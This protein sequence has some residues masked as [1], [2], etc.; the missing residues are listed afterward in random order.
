MAEALDDLKKQ[1]DDA[2]KLLKDITDSKGGIQALTDNFEKTNETLKETNGQAGDLIAN[3][4]KM[5]GGNGP[6]SATLADLSRAFL[7]TTQ[8]TS[9]FGGE[10]QALTGVVSSVLGPELGKIVASVGLLPSVFDTFTGTTRQFKKDTLELGST[11]G[12]SYEQII[13]KTL[14]YQ[15]A[16]LLANNYTF[17]G[18]DAVR[19]SAVGMAQYGL[20]VDEVTRSFNVAG[21][22]QN[23]LSTG[24]LLATDSGLQSSKV[25]E[26]M[27][28]SARTM[29]YDVENSAK[30]IVAL[31]NIARDTG[32][33]L[34]QI[35]DKVFNTAKE[36]SRLGL[37]VDS[38]SP[39]IQRFTENLGAGFKGL[40]VDEVNKLMKGLESQINTTNAAFMSM[41]GGLSRPGAGV[42]EAQLAFEDAFKNPIE[43][44]K[45]LSS[46]LAGVTGGKIIKFEEARANPELANQFKL[47]RDLLGQLTGNRDPQSQRT[48]LA[49][50]SDLQS[51]RQLSSSQ[52]KTL[53]D[54]MKSG[55][56][57]QNEMASTT[58]Q[59]DRITV[60]LQTETNILLG[61]ILNKLAPSQ[62]QG[63]LV[64][65]GG[66]YAQAGLEQTIKFAQTI[67]DKI[68]EFSAGKGLDLSSVKDKY[69]NMI[70]SQRPG[71]GIQPGPAFRSTVNPFGESAGV[72]IPS[73]VTPTA[74][75]SSVPA[76][77]PGIT[78][79]GGNASKTTNA[80]GQ[81]DKHITVSFAG[82]DEL[83]RAIANSATAKINDTNHGRG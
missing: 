74:P 76:P 41:Q 34:T 56:E 39:V 16:V 5:Y 45:S 26:M 53:Q 78:S 10:L 68:G 28:K 71:P 1:L 23:L 59:L 33:P 4:A 36:F 31:E 79:T 80:P 21:T 83:T 62:V 2:K 20:S 48:L 19:R 13:G 70:N 57:K 69:D 40:A 61:N 3:F 65:K 82:N 51:G 49:I 66:E 46:T 15:N 55:Q 38:M 44:M 52:E 8:A 58:Q 12:T 6:L 67:G 7:G 63:E 54:S 64:R 43:I 72:A 11:Y 37:T 17:E 35:A 77:G 27:A 60:G 32:L 75:I 29:G 9:A 73:Q 30:P 22:S 18:I 24:F 42:A 14:D 47:Q 25:F 81:T 50:L